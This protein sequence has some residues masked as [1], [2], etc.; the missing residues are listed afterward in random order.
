M[1]NTQSSRPAARGYS[2]IC[3][4]AG[5]CR[6]RPHSSLFIG[7]SAHRPAKSYPN[8]IARGEMG[9]LSFEPY[10]SLILPYWAF[11]T[12]PIARKSAEA[13]WSIF[14]SYLE[15]GDFVGA[16]MTRKFIQMGMTRARR[17][18]NHK[19]GRKYDDDGKQLPNWTEED[20]DG[21]RREKEQASEI[22]KEYWRRC[23]SSERMFCRASDNTAIPQGF[24]SLRVD[25][26]CISLCE[27]LLGSM[28]NWSIGSSHILAYR[29]LCGCCTSSIGL[30]SIV[31]Q[32]LLGWLVRS[33]MDG[34]GEFYP[35]IEP[36]CKCIV[37][38]VQHPASQFPTT[39][40]GSS[41]TILATMM[42]GSSSA[43]RMILQRCTA[44]S[45][46]RDA[47]G[48]APHGSEIRLDPQPTPV[49]TMVH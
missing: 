16:D 46:R 29:A 13:L 12:V 24:S 21:K 34:L 47:S 39:K 14:E 17:Y 44:G 15:R 25:V 11:R 48:I 27:S 45:G 1:L 22:F 18:A 41:G 2:G 30:G 38:V 10:K 6:L 49:S 36:F 31:F 4:A 26:G 8:R 32:S 7:A 28:G 23:T 33:A 40:I 20:L 19:G 42:F 9:V 5:S 3:T 43:D 37:R 35:L